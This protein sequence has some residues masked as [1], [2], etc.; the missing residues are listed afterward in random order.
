MLQ[1]TDWA[2]DDRKHLVYIHS[3]V[4][5]D[6]LKFIQARES[7]P[8]AGGILLGKV[9]GPHLEIIEATKPSRFDKRL[10]YLFERS[11]HGH[12]RI[13]FQRWRHSKGEIRYLG[14]WHTHP[15]DHPNPSGTDLHE[16]RKLAVDRIDQ[17]PVLAMIVGRKGLHVELM[18][19]NGCR[20]LLKNL[21]S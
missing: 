11:P 1:L 18:F 9:R 8:E 20:T 21:S 12:R 16:W 15:E 19:A 10:R 17:R 2:T 4:L 6:I 5:E 14:E 7:D 3:S 13:A